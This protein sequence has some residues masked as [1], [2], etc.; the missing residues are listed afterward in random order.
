MHNPE[1]SQESKTLTC[2]PAKKDTPDPTVS[3]NQCWLRWMLPIDGRDID[4]VQQTFARVAMLGSNTIG[5]LLFMNIFKSLGKKP[6]NIFLFSGFGKL[7]DTV[8]G[9]NPALVQD[10]FQRWTLGWAQTWVENVY[11]R[12]TSRLIGLLFTT[13]RSGDLGDDIFWKLLGSHVIHHS[14]L[15][16][17][18]ILPRSTSLVYRSF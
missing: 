9:R 11:P 5:R 13:W 1:I 2:C 17:F 18:H 12:S 16:Q 3:T 10:F 15:F 4:L 7:K 6:E 14:H 8:F